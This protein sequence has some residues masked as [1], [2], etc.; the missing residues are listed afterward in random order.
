MTEFRHL[1]GLHGLP[2]ARDC[3]RTHEMK[4][5]PDF[6]V[7]G[8]LR[9]GTTTLYSLLTQVP[10]ICMTEFKEPDFFLTDGSMSKGLDWYADLFSDPDKVCGE[11][12]PNYSSVDRFPGVAE[13]IHS[14][15]PGA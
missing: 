9:T 10:S 4:P 13:R 2:R 11:V 6:V 12:S 1:S 14:V 5:L 3:M 15:S 7:V 8:G